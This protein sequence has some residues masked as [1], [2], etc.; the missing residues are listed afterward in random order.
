[1]GISLGDKFLKM[2][3]VNQKEL[4]EKVESMFEKPKPKSEDEDMEID[5]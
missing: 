5:D 4:K 2:D 1:M 3:V